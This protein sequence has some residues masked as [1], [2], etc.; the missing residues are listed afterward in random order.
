MIRQPKVGETGEIRFTVD[1]SH[2]I[3]FAEG[4]MPLVLSTPNLV[5]FLENAARNVLVPLFEPGETCV[6]TDVD[7]QHL[8]AAPLGF[9]VICTGRVI[10]VEKN[11]VTFQVEAR[12]EQELIARGIHKRAVL[13]ID[14]FAKRIA[15]KRA[16]K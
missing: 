9:E 8:A 2:V 7:F 10:H 5:W 11:I 15:A 3:D 4:N 6:G 12:D 13:K 14:R 16:R 1:E